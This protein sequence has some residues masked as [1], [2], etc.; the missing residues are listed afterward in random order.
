ME[1]EREPQ[2][3]CVPHGDG[4]RIAMKEAEDRSKPH[5][6]VLVVDD[7][8]VVRRGVVGLLETDPRITVVGQAG[9]TAEA[10]DQLQSTEPDVLLLDLRFP[11]DDGYTLLDW[12][13][14]HAPCVNVIVLSAFVDE[15][16]AR[17][18]L[19]NE[20]AGYLLKEA[21]G[22]AIV[23]AVI[24]SQKGG[25]PVLSPAVRSRL[26]KTPAREDVSS[27]AR[28]TVHLAPR[29][30][31]VLELIGEGTPNKEIADKLHIAEKTI[32]NLITCLFRKLGVSNRTE[33]ALL[34]KQKKQER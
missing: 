17:M 2:Y 32:R 25:P 28:S 26:E 4:P 33:A 12:T 16:V 6:T 9:S 10:T 5:V 30:R 27:E 15:Q 29:E 22:D 1:I 34:W 14:R 21:E 13:R 3:L 31:Q 23:E 11:D 18:A 24:S 19:N 8:E 20:I 7:H